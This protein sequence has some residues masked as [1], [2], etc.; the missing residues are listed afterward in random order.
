MPLGC[1]DQGCSGL[2]TADFFGIG[3]VGR[4]LSE[5][6]EYSLSRL[7][8]EDEEKETLWFGMALR[9]SFGRC[10]TNLC[11]SFPAVGVGV[12]EAG[13]AS[14]IL[15]SAEQSSEPEARKFL[16]SRLNGMNDKRM[17]WCHTKLR[18]CRNKAKRKKGVGMKEN[19]EE[20]GLESETP[21]CAW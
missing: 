14:N 8:F 13:V 3:D 6:E 10:Q 1:G 15:D 16:I 18:L 19:W 7:P 21:H 20:I 5:W 9:V 11:L 17:K 4:E 12:A 2:F